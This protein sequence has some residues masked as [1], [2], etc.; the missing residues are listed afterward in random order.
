ME[1]TR[2]TFPQFLFLRS[3]F[4]S[5]S[6]DGITAESLNQHYARISTHPCYQ[7]PK[8]KLTIANR[9]DTA[10]LV[11]EY[12]F[13]EILDKL[14][15]TATGMDLLPAWFLRLRA[16]V[17]NGPLAGLL[18]KS[19]ATSTVPKQWKLA[20]ITPVLKITSP[21][22]HVVFR[23]ISITPV[24][25][26]TFER[27]TC[28][29]PRVHLSSNSQASCLAELRGSLCIPSNWIH[30]CRGAD[31]KYEG[32]NNDDRSSN[33]DHRSA[34]YDYSGYCCHSSVCYGTAVVQP[35]RSG[36]HAGL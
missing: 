33:D 32:A 21:Q 19:I 30:D 27:D 1:P 20:S 26:R 31:S 4:P 5:I 22:K 15:N 11:A 14:Y 16:P 17:F 6:L 28:H 7:P 24:L 35:V 12:R 3:S 25:S 10:E 34:N 36:H 18:N 9:A 29:C 8:R 23:P 2:Q 13:F